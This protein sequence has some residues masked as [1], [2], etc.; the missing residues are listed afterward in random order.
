[1]RTQEINRKCTIVADALMG[2]TLDMVSPD[3]EIVHTFYVPQ[4]RHRASQ[5]LDLVEPGYALQ[6]GEGCVCFQPR[7]G[8][9]VSHHPEAL[10]SDANPDFQPLT[11]AAKY[12]RELRMELDQIRNVRLD[13]IKEKRI[14]EAEKIE[15]TEVIPEAKAEGKPEAK[16][17]DKPEAK[18]EDKAGS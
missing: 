8:A 16:P 15:V 6:I 4:G 18:P 11:G 3:G 14:R 17:E 9:I 12:E 5:W 2:G 7:M 13:L 10:A 1:M